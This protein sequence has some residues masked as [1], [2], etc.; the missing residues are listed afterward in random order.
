MSRRPHIINGDEVF[1]KRALPR[2]TASIPERLIVTN[3]LILQDPYPQDKSLLQTYFR[4]YGRIKKIDLENGIIDYEDYDDVDRVLLA[5][6]HYVRD[7]EISVTK[8]SPV[9]QQED[10]D[11]HH[12]HQRS[13]RRH[14]SKHHNHNEQPERIIRFS[15][16]SGVQQ[17]HLENTAFDQEIMNHNGKKEQED[18][19]E[20]E[21]GEMNDNDSSIRYEQLEEQFQEYKK[22][23]EIEICSLRMDLEHTKQ[24]LA[25]L[26]QEKLDLLIKKQ[27]LF[28]NEL[29]LRL[30]PERISMQTQTIDDLYQSPSE[31]SN[32]K[33]K[34]SLSPSINREFDYYS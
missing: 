14:R 9:E 2:L 6:P 33:R 21:D 18:E 1:V 30:F 19:E 3:R 27:Q 10:S 24:Q 31:H 11:N 12:H 17:N 8:Y 32:K 4:K 28:H 25:D 13:H 29:T 26:T 15:K 23:K 20:A 22:A 16:H 34:L 5:R 7:E